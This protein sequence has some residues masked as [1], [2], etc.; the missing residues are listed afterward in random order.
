ME[1]IEERIQKVEER[2]KRLGYNE[3]ALE[4]KR[5]ELQR[6]ETE[7]LKLKKSLHD[8]TNE[9]KAIISGADKVKA[10][11]AELR[12]QHTLKRPASQLPE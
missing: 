7:I 1:T 11:I 4:S 5:Q 12:N 8:Q 3:T 10:E 2:E 6:E 9:A